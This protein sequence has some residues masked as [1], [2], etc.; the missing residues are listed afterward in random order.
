MFLA[1]AH[2]SPHCCLHV[3]SRD[4]SLEIGKSTATLAAQ[5]HK[6]VKSPHEVLREVAALWVTK[7]KGGRAAYCFA[8]IV[9]LNEVFGFGFA[10]PAISLA[11]AVH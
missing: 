9:A 8:S 11:V 5:T 2:L 7:G 1:S 10:P 4:F 3:H 6:R